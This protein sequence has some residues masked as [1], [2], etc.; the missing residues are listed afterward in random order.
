MRRRPATEKGQTLPLVCLFI[1]ILLGFAGLAIDVGLAMVTKRRVQAAVDL[2]LLSG[3]QKLPDSA[4]AATDAFDHTRT[5]YLQNR[6]RG[7]DNH[8]GQ[9]DDD[10]AVTATTG[11]MVAG[12][13][14]PDKVTLVARAQ[15]PTYFLR[16][17]GVD[18]FDISA[19]GSACGPCDSSPVSYDVVVVLDRSYSMCLDSNNNSNNCSDIANAVAGIKTL[20]PFFNPQTDRVGLVLLSGEDNVAPF[21]HTGTAPCDSANVNDA[22]TQGKGRYYK[23]AGDFFD[24]TPASHD[25]WLVAP[26]ASTFKNPDG[27][28]NTSSAIV[29]TLNCVQHKY[30]T[31]IAPAVQAATDELVAHGRPNVAKV[32]VYFGDGGGNTQPML[33]DANGNSTATPSWYTPTA[34][35]NL[36]PCHDAIGQAAVAKAAGIR[37][38]TIGYDLNSGNANSCDMNNNGTTEPGIDARTTLTQMASAPTDFYEKASAGDVLQIFVAI[39]HSITDGGVRLVK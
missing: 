19:S 36:R 8:D 18:H 9:R 35:N 1:V 2:G 30:W 24:G 7:D 29:S 17:F 6:R 3:A 10:V 14:N 38:I 4:A 16:I 12:C 21:D 26:L 28:L 5:N 32:I 11:C 25:A 27:T 34:G 37:V 39:G 15:S 33:R 13:V 20:L 23:S 22:S 31:P